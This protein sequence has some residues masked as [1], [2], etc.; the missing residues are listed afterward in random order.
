M[1]NKLFTIPHVLLKADETGHMSA[2]PANKKIEVTNFVPD[3]NATHLF[4]D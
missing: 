1:H 2:I 3:V 4:F